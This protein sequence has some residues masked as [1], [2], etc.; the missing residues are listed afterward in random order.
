MIKNRIVRW[1]TKYLGIIG[2]RLKLSHFPVLQDFY[3]GIIGIV[4]PDKDVW[5]TM[6]DQEMLIPNPR[7]DALGRMIYIH[8][9]WEDTV[10]RVLCK[11]VHPGMTVLDIGAHVGYYT[12][13]MAKRVG[14][15]GKVIAFEPNPVVRKIIEQNVDRNSYSHVVISPYALFSKEGYG[16]LNGRDNLNSCLRPQPTKTDGSA[17]IMVFDR[18]KKV[19]GID[20]VDFLKMDVEGAEL[21]ILFG[22]QELLEK[23]H[24]VMVIEVHVDGLIQFQHSESEVHEYIQSFGYTMEEIWSQTDT[25]TV[26]CKRAESEKPPLP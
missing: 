11:E 3:L 17:S 14:M 8:G 15:E 10:T 9:S 19:M 25:V 21:D 5:V 23:Y 16:L 22:M 26:L 24:P 13:I 7:R 6:D 20:K 1:I 18:L 4:L 12:L 2:N